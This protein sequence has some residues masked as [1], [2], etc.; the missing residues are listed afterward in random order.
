M[1]DAPADT[2]A[3]DQRDLPER[4]KTLQ[5]RGSRVHPT[6]DRETLGM[7][8]E[9]EPRRH[10]GP[11]LEVALGGGRPS[12]ARNSRGKPRPPAGAYFSA[13]VRL[14]RYTWLKHR[15]SWSSGHFCGFNDRRGCRPSERGLLTD[16]DRVSSRAAARRPPPRACAFSQRA[17]DA[18]TRSDSRESSA[19]GWPRTGPPR[20]ARSPLPL[21][22]HLWRAPGGAVRG[23]DPPATPHFSAPRR[24]FISARDRRILSAA[25]ASSRRS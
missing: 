7:L 16:A 24:I 18:M 12:A 15:P 25:P 1:R 10:A 22:V 14:H 4:R 3:R 5:R 13:A 20:R 6:D 8:E 17:S 2:R 23:Q 9:C 19:G 21:P 11:S